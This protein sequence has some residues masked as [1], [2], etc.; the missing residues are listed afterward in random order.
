MTLKQIFVQNLKEFRK[1]EGLSQM[2]LA[3]YCNTATSYI[4]EIEIGRRF[5][6]MEMIEKIADIL[7]IEPY[8]FFK[9]QK[10]NNVNP[11]A[12]NIFPRLPNSMKKQIT[13]QIKTQI[14]QS[15]NEILSEINEIINKY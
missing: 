12:E 2:K 6:S 11:D 15:T 10:D 5:P 1:K 3:E 4:G 14:H 13:T 8:R 9:N 7:R